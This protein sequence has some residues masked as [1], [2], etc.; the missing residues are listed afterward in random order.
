MK[1]VFTLLV[2]VLFGVSFAQTR[3]DTITG[4][5]DINY[6]NSLVLQ[7]CNERTKDHSVSKTSN[8]I[9]FKCAEYQSS[10]MAKYSVCTHDDNMLHKGVKL[11]TIVDRKKYFDKNNEIYSIAEVCTFAYFEKGV[12]TYE[13]LANHVI[14]NFFKSTPHRNTILNDYPYGNFSCTLGTYDGQRGVYV[15][16]FFSR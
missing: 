13:D 8:T 9:T 1:K 10:Y 2:S 5:V 6:L 12:V 11:V 4:N 14:D 7:V 3:K 15:T 16:G